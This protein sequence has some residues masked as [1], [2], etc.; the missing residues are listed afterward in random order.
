MDEESEVP[1]P[2][3]D[4][5][6]DVSQPVGEQPAETTPAGINCRYWEALTQRGRG[7]SRPGLSKFNPTQPA[8]KQLIQELNLIVTVKPPQAQV[9]VMFQSGTTTVGGCFSGSGSATVPFLNPGDISGY[10]LVIYSLGPQLCA[11]AIALTT[12]PAVTAVLAAYLQAGG[13]LFINGEYGQGSGDGG[14]PACMAGRAA[15]N[16]WLTGQLG[17]TMTFGQGGFLTNDGTGHYWQS[18]DNPGG[19]AVPGPWINAGP[20]LAS[21]V[22]G[23]GSA[24]I[25]VGNGRALFQGITPVFPWSTDPD[26]TRNNVIMAIEKVGQGYLILGGDSDVY[27]GLPI[28]VQSDFPN[29]SMNCALFTNLANF[30]NDQMQALVQ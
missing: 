13:R 24:V 11:D 16:S 9:G 12:Q 1:L 17:T 20:Q 7:G 3:P 22:Y 4:K 18:P 26:N 25:N 10:S 23:A 21:S 15:V 27:P 29:S 19:Y 5:G 30:T 28:P 14:I 6:I 8:G 2:F